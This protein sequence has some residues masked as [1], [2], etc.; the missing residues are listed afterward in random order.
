MKSKDELIGMVNKQAESL[1]NRTGTLVFTFTEDDWIEL[2]SR[3][4]MSVDARDLRKAKL[5]KGGFIK[6]TSTYYGR[7]RLFLKVEDKSVELQAGSDGYGDDAD[8]SGYAD[9][10]TGQCAPDVC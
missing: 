1:E 6:E 4:L 2:A 8:D 7:A 5:S 3:G 10:E 9:S